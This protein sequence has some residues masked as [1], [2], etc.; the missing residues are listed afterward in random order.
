MNYVPEELVQLRVGQQF[1]SV[2]YS[3][4][5]QEFKKY[6]CGEEGHSTDKHQFENILTAGT[7]MFLSMRSRICSLLL[8]D[9]F[10]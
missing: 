1:L 6:K 8:M 3:C 5:S 7:I 10:T 4:K 9:H 2:H